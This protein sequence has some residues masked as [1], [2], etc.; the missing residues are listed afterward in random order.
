M[1]DK[2]KTLFSGATQ[3]KQTAGTDDKLAVAV[4]LFEAAASDGVIEQ[5]E[6]N[7]IT[8]LLKA[9]YALSDAAVE[10]LCTS[11]RAVQAD[12]IEIT[13][14]TREI[15]EQFA[16]EERI[17][18]IDMLWDVV[19]AD[20]KVDDFEA[21]LMRRIGGLIYVDDKANGAARKRADV[22]QTLSQQTR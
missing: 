19:Y 17:S 7:R 14:F 2:L 9:H 11:A 1:L 22:R 13:R 8:A 3:S 21:N 20:G 5:E 12:A 6:L 16:F 4:L 10:E 15:K 18:F